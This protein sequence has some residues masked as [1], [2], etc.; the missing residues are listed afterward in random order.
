LSSFW[1]ILKQQW[2][3]EE[4]SV[5]SNMYLDFRG[6]HVA[7]LFSF[8][9]CVVFLCFVYLRLVYPMLPV[10]GFSILDCPFSFRQRLIN[11][12]FSIWHLK[13]IE[14][15]G[16]THNF[17]SGPPKDH[18]NSNFWDFYLIIFLNGINWLKK[19]HRKTQNA[20]PN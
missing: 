3:I 1:L 14:N 16:V 10:S 20:E 12:W 5:F 8:L 15:G 17:E 19:S 11:T 18:F 6:V 2:T 7:H 13:L 9:C 4:I